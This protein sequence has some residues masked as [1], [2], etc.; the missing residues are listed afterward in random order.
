[1]EHFGSTAV[2]GMA[3]KPIV[4]LLV[5][6]DDL[7]LASSRNRWPGAA[8]LRE[9]RRDPSSQAGYTCAGAGLA[10]STSP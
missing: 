10:R 8:W 2:P 4:D 6:V 7:A 9:L 1:V 5:G 3:G